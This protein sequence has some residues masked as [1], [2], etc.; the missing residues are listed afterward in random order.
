MRNFTL[1]L[2][3]VLFWYVTY[4]TGSIFTGFLFGTCYG[5]IFRKMF[6]DWLL[7]RTNKSQEDHQ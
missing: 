4:R 5:I 3:G 7:N 2:L 6:T 1:A